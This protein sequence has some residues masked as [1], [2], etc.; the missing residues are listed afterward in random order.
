M[1]AV[2]PSRIVGAIACCRRSQIKTRR[3]DPPAANIFPFGLNAT[4]ERGAVM[5]ERL[6]GMLSRSCMS[7]NRIVPSALA[8]ASVVPSGVRLNAVM[9]FVELARRW[10]GTAGWRGSH[11][12]TIPSSPPPIR[13]RPSALNNMGWIW[14]SIIMGGMEGCCQSHKSTCPPGPDEASS[15]LSGL[16]A[17]LVTY[18]L[19][20]INVVG[21]LLG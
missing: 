19:F 21:K 18:P 3:S 9:L 8:V 7:H 14:A 16:K 1:P 12:R 11:N 10:G 13:N 17:T 6:V 4:A 15:C 2:C 5:L 20:P